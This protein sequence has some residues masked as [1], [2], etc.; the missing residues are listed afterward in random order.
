MATRFTDVLY[1]TMV[2]LGGDINWWTTK[3][4]VAGLHEAGAI[5][6]TIVLVQSLLKS[7]PFKDFDEY[8]N[9]LGFYRKVKGNALLVQV[10]RPGADPDMSRF[11]PWAPAEGETR[12]WRL[13]DK[14]PAELQARL[15]AH[16][17]LPA[18]EDA[19]RAAPE[20]G[21]AAD[22][23]AL[24]APSRASYLAS[25]RERAMARRDRVIARRRR[26]WRPLRSHTRAR[27]RRQRRRPCRAAPRVPSRDCCTV[28]GATRSS[29]PSSRMASRASSRDRV[30]AWRVRVIARRRRR[31]RHLRSHS[32][33]W[34][35][36]QRRRRAA[37]RRLSRRA[38]VVL[39]SA[40][41]V[42]RAHH[43]VRH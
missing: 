5:F 4:I 43:R 14:L 6:V 24:R 40:P 7:K 36:R 23:D 10:R 8:S 1:E 11:P 37:P 9:P 18:S 22:D 30:I 39:S 33:A 12:G 13:R 2:A 28:V 32:R 38:A 35:R 42:H 16:L 25:S 3:E 26:R 27:R 19:E 20:G 41:C 21:A 34:R 31:W 15:R 29:L 17:G